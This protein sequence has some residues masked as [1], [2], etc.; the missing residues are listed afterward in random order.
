[1]K[2]ITFILITLM[3]VS[4]AISDVNQENSEKLIALNVLRNRL[5]N[6]QLERSF[7]ALEKNDF[8][9]ASSKIKYLLQEHFKL[10]YNDILPI[11]HNY[12]KIF[13]LY[14][15]PSFSVHP[16][17]YII[18]IDNDLQ[19]FCLCGFPQ[20]HFNKLINKGLINVDI[21]KRKSIFDIT[22]LYIQTVIMKYDAEETIISN[23]LKITKSNDDS[24]YYTIQTQ[25][26]KKDITINYSFKLTKEGILLLERK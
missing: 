23:S 3:M 10:D 21:K 14:W 11:Q 8:N 2:T 1:M 26:D 13:R 22:M 15:T 9:Y 19:V 5:I 24:V 25:S 17:I 4:I 6:I 12:K 18:A 16:E 20:N 7:N